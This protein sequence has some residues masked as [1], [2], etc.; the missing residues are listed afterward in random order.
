MDEEVVLEQGDC[1]E[2]FI[3][4]EQLTEDDMAE[5]LVALSRSGEFSHR[6]G[7]E[8]V[9]ENVDLY[10]ILYIL[11]ETSTTAYF[12]KIWGFPSTVCGTTRRF[13]E[14]SQLVVEEYDPVSSAGRYTRFTPKYPVAVAWSPATPVRA[15]IR[16]ETPNM[17]HHCIFAL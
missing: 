10:V 13:V 6:S 4:E 15:I 12:E 14:S 9:A 17:E 16:R 2:E 1:V 3:V 5:S 11:A 8:C 7:R